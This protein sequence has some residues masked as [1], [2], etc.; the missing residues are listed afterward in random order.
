[1]K[2]VNSPDKHWHLLCTV[3]H[4][5]VLY[6][7]HDP[8]VHRVD[9]GHLVNCPGCD[10]RMPVT[11]EDGL[12]DKETPTEI[13]ASDE[14]TE[15]DVVDA[16]LEQAVQ[17][18]L[19]HD[20]WRGQLFIMQCMAIRVSMRQLAGAIQSMMRG[21]IILYARDEH[22]KFTDEVLAILVKTSDDFCIFIKSDKQTIA[23]VEGEMYTNKSMYG[24]LDKELP[25]SYTANLDSI[26]Q[27][28][29]QI[30]KSGPEKTRQLANGE[31]VN[32]YVSRR[33]YATNRSE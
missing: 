19:S 18:A 14:E 3:C 2:I 21:S 11:C 33:T 25:R 1:M 32:D 28:L 12:I 16:D 10:A 22:N 20:E 29:R 27:T 17:V 5:E 4:T 23:V 13:G 6:D 31:E 8:A 24:W 7:F 9:R 15:V 30:I 26:G